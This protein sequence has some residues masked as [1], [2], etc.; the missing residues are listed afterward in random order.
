[1]KLRTSIRYR[2][3]SLVFHATLIERRQQSCFAAITNDP[4]R[5]IDQEHVRRLIVAA[6]THMNFLFDDLAFGALSLLDYYGRLVTLLHRSAPI[7]NHKWTG[8]LSWANAEQAAS[9]S[10]QTVE[11]VLRQNTE[12]LHGLADFRNCLIHEESHRAGAEWSWNFKSNLEV[13]VLI[14]PSDSFRN[15]SPHLHQTT[16]GPL[17]LVWLRPVGR[18]SDDGCLL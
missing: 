5:M 15:S 14:S 16:A 12:W 13:G 10:L 1:M 4:K 8:V 2:F 9:S 17:G 11:L 7:K 6:T 3:D 18:G